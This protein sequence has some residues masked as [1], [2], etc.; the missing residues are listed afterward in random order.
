MPL[1]A[2][3]LRRILFG[4]YQGNQNMAIH[5]RA[6][7]RADRWRPLSTRRVRGDD[8]GVDAPLV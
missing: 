3:E 1:S 7:Q 8:L 2:K 5:R 6:W 4:L